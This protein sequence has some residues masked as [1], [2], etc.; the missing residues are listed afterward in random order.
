[1]FKVKNHQP[2][3]GTNTTYARATHSVAYP[4]AKTLD[5]VTLTFDI[6]P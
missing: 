1:L 4:L 5:T 6:L 3:H 2:F